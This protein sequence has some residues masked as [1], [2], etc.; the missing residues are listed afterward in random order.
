MP[1]STFT[2]KLYD[3][4]KEMSVVETLSLFWAQSVSMNDELKTEPSFQS[5][6]VGVVYEH[7][8]P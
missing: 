6:F 7:P 5:S 1:A 2:E 8:D 3:L 4:A